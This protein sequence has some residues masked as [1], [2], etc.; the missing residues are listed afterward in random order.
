MLRVK[1]YEVTGQ[2]ALKNFGADWQ[3]FVQLRRREGYVQEES[4][5]NLFLLL[6]VSYKAWY[7]RALALDLTNKREGANGKGRD[8]GIIAC[9]YSRISIGR[10]LLSEHTRHQHQVVIMHPHQ[11][12]WL[13]HLHAQ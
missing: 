10:E 9:L 2:N 7:W 13:P 3:D 6:W 8:E 12:V 4:Y 11:I 1:A 5:V